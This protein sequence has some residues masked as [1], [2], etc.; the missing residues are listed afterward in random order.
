MPLIYFETLY[1]FPTKHRTIRTME[2]L[3]RLELP[4]TLKRIIVRASFWPDKSVPFEDT[5]L[6]IILVQPYNYFLQNGKISYKENKPAT[7]FPVAY[8]PSVEAWIVYYK[9]NSW[10]MFNLDKK[11]LPY[12][13]NVPKDE[14]EDFFELTIR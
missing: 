10:L 8:V 9:D 6:G 1:T 12:P 4:D 3:Y 11:Q 2:K 14:F 5:K 7:I 13:Y